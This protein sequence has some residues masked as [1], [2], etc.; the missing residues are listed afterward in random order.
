METIRFG[1]DGWRAVIARDFTFAA[2]ERLT[3]AAALYLKRNPAPGTKPTLVVGYDTRFL[4]DAFAATTAEVFAGNGFSVI[5]ATQACPTPSLSFAVKHHKA[6]AGVMIT[7]SHNPGIFNGYKLKSH[8][9]GA[10]DTPTLKGVERCLNRRQVRKLSLEQGLKSGKIVRIDL[11]KAHFSALR[12]LI[13]WNRFKKWPLRVAHDALHGVGAGC[14]EAL[15]RGTACQV[16]GI[17]TARDPMFGGRSPEPIPSNYAE[18]TAFLRKHPHDVCLVTDGDADRIGGLQGRGRPLTTHEIICLLLDHLIVHRGQRGR[19]V[20]AIT[21]SSMVDLICAAHDLPLTETGVGFKYICAEMVKGDVMAGVEES[22][23]VALRGHIPERDGL[24]AGL[25]LLELLGS[26][27][28]TVGH[29]LGKLER[30]F[31]PHRYGRV[32]L[33]ESRDRIRSC[34]DKL[35]SSP[36]DRLGRSPVKRVQSFDGVKMTADD[37]SWLMLRGSG[38]EPVVRV[39]AEAGSVAGVNRLLAKGRQL[40]KSA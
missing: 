33:H 21:T 29:L 32:D 18:A 30:R 23:G 27:G 25:L 22:G 16:T 3:Q 9:G 38:T 34:L 31:G 15:L 37:G 26:T 36:P 1:T 12:R 8:F 40:L 14:F 28:L 2:V 24:A 11:R 39:Y 6:A 35:K 7:A 5:L 4:S 17:H 19:V 13:D 20:K 10:A